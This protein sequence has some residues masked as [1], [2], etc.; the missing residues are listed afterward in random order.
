MEKV[1]LNIENLGFSNDKYFKINNIDFDL[2]NGDIFGLIGPSGCGKS[3]L[4]N[5]ILGLKNKTKGRIISRID[6]KTVDIR[7]IIGYSPQSNSLF[8]NLTLEENIKIFGKLSGINSKDLKINSEKLLKKLSLENAVDK[9]ISELSGGMKK[10][11]DI[12]C[13]LIHAPKIIILDEPF[14]GLDLNLRIFLWEII[15]SFS[16]NGRIIIITSHMLDDIQKYCNKIGLILKKEYYDTDKIHQ[17]MKTNHT[18]TI[19]SFIQKISK[20]D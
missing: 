18:S 20:G 13:A 1:E 2:K 5:V 15:V 8:F 11:A 10:R 4:I 19:E 17:M 9:K 3:S 14:V 6:G 12:A 16:K 7:S